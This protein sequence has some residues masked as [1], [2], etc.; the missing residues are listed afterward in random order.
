G[1][2]SVTQCPLPVGEYM[3]YTWKATQYGSSWYHSHF[4]LQAFQGV[5][6]GIVIDGRTTADCDQDLGMIFLNDWD[7]H[8]VDEQ[9]SS[10][11]WP[12]PPIFTTGLINRTNVFG[13]HNN[14]DQTGSRLNISFAANLRLMA[15]RWGGRA[16]HE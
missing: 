14:E 5:F 4:A 6:G 10:A 8:A 1:V 9:Y 2:S 15:T 3:A 12:G 11:Q 7:H 13:Y 16:L